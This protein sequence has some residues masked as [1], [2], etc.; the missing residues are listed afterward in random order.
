MK[1]PPK[2]AIHFAIQQ[3]LEPQTELYRNIRRTIA[4]RRIVVVCTCIP[5]SYSRIGDACALLVKYVNITGLG[6][7]TLI[8]KVRQLVRNAEPAIEAGS[9]RRVFIDRLICLVL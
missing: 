3:L 4:V 8:G 7:E 1:D 5:R 6:K 9:I 2:R